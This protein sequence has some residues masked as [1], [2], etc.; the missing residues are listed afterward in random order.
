MKTSMEQY[1]ATIE[2]NIVFNNHKNGHV[3][4][5]GV[6]LGKGG[7]GFVYETSIPGYTR[8]MVLK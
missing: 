6:M 3:F 2:Q 5:R 7:F 4:T 1:R 8:R